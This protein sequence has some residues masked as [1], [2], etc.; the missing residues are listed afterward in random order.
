MNTLILGL[1]LEGGYVKNY[2]FTES[3]KQIVI[4]SSR[5][6]DIRLAKSLAQNIEG[7]LELEDRGWVYHSFSM[8][9]KVPLVVPLA[10][11]TKGKFFI[12]PIEVSAQSISEKPV[13]D[14]A[15][16]VGELGRQMV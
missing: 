8:N 5:K 7:V 3:K 1:K 13:F 6:A 4:G 16:T 14:D 12:G 11:S 15:E 10:A 9:D 2:R